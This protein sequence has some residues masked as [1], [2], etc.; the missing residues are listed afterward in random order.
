MRHGGL[1]QVN[2]YTT[3]ASGTQYRYKLEDG[4]VVGVGGMFPKEPVDHANFG[5]NHP[6]TNYMH[7]YI[8]CVPDYSFAE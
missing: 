4:L 8:F 2:R 3:S 1:I 7:G 5:V 6:S